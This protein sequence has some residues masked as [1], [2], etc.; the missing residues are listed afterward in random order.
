MPDAAPTSNLNNLIPNYIIKFEQPNKN[1]ND[2]QN[3]KIKLP[4]LN[5]HNQNPNITTI[6]MLTVSLQWLYGECERGNL[7]ICDSN[8][9]V[10]VSVAWYKYT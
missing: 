5:W 4:A 7:V 9:H 10:I 8:G 3:P 1:D 6:Q 2:K